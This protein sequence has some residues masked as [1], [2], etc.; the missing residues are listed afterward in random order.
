MLPFFFYNARIFKHFNSD[1][2]HSSN[3]ILLFRMLVLPSLRYFDCCNKCLLAV[4][5]TFVLLS[6]SFPILFVY[7]AF[8][9]CFP[10]EIECSL[11][12]PVSSKPWNMEILLIFHLILLLYVKYC[13]PPHPLFSQFSL[14]I[15]S[16]SCFLAFSFQHTIYT[17]T[18]SFAFLY[19]LS[20]ILQ[21]FISFWCAV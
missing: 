19:Y 15:I 8:E 10:P 11:I 3:I 2:S 4:M 1:T 21:S 18:V 5:Y 13:L 14:Q 16:I 6:S 12:G 17:V 20:L 7:I 9:F